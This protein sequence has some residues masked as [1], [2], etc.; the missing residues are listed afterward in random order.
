MSAPIGNRFWQMRSKHG[1]DRIF[2]TP[3]IL[4]EAICE[5]FQWCED[6]PFYKAEAKTINIGDFQS[7]VEIAKI[8]VMRPF[9]IQGLCRFLDTNTQYFND[10]EGSVKGKADEL[11]KGF[12]L[13]LMRAR[14]IIYDQKFSGAASGFFNSTVIIRDLCLKDQSDINVNDS[15]KATAELFPWK[16]SEKEN[17]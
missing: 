3:E 12:S 17:E 9:T 1:R 4:W 7:Q 2:G 8:P 10:F 14:E 6:N 5:Y 16:D 15:R 11:S 13:I